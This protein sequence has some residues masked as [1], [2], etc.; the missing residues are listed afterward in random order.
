[1]CIYIGCR[2]YRVYARNLRFIGKA[3]HANHASLP[4][5]GVFAYK[6]WVIMELIECV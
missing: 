6:V 3:L 5:R 1:M 4:F 2:V